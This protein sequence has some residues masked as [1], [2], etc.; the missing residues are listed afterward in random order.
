M[1]VTLEARLLGSPLY[2]WVPLRRGTAWPF[3][4]GVL[5]MQHPTVVFLAN[6]YDVMTLAELEKQPKQ[7]Y[8]SLEQIFQDGWVID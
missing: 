3:E 5:H 4:L 2:P 8:P 1:M 7:S 6:L